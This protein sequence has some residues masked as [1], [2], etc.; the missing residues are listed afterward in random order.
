MNG[1][2]PKIL[3]GLSLQNVAGSRQVES[4]VLW[5]V[6]RESELQTALEHVHREALMREPLFVQVFQR[7][8]G[9]A[10]DRGVGEGEALQLL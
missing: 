3:D 8:T 1:L 10:T 9:V 7:V 5:A 4:F 6:R 2:T